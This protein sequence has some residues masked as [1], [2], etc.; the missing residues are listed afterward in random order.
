MPC[1]PVGDRVGDDLTTAM[2][3]RLS[4]DASGWERR[5]VV[6]TL[7]ALSLALVAVWLA[8]SLFPRTHSQEALLY[9]GAAHL[10]KAD[11]RAL[12]GRLASGINTLVVFLALHLISKSGLVARWFRRPRPVTP[13]GALLLGSLAGIAVA[14]LVAAVSFPGTVYTGYLLE[15]QYG[16]SNVA[17]QVWLI[18]Y[19]KGLAAN[20]LVYVVAGGSVAWTLLRFPRNWAYILTLGFVA[21]SALV[22]FIYPWVIAP[23]SNRFYPLEDQVL[24]ADVRQLSDKAG[25]KIDE[26]LVMEAS[27][28]TSR[29]NAYFAGMGSS[30]QVVLYDTLLMTHSREQV[31]LVVAHEM[32]HWRHGHVSLGLWVT[33]VGTLIVL[34]VFRWS[35]PG[36]SQ[37]RATYAGLERV[38]LLLLVVSTLMGYVASPIANAIS[39]RF[40]VSADEYSLALTGDP[41]T[42]I[43]TQVNLAKANLSDVEPPRFVRWIAWT[44]P[45]TMERISMAKGS[46]PRNCGCSV[47]LHQTRGRDSGGSL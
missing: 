13:K 38:L 36:L 22:T 15:R 40:E 35:M 30:R 6:K 14:C 33:M 44:H 32:G 43:S 31:G 3:K 9:F 27:A 16:L 12:K 47:R 1:L 41:E 18:D 23:W 37:L 10:E 11:A 34:L 20:A 19:L 24:L 46:I 21:A 17:F 26:V 29:V 39:R 7:W 5:Y 42:F 28:K 2:D 25:L 4:S 8:S 45:T